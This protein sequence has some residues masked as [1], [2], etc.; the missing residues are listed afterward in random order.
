MHLDLQRTS[1][2]KLSGIHATAYFGLTEN[3]AFFRWVNRHIG[4]LKDETGRTLV[5]G[6]EAV[7]RLLNN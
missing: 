4:E 1:A 5:G 2:Q 6:H 3:I 7:V